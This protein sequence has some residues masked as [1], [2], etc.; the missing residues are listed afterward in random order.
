MKDKPNIVVFMTDQ[1]NAA[2]IGPGGLADTPHV[3]AF[4]ESAVHFPRA[5]C[6]APHCCPSRATLFTGLYPS[7]HGVWNNVEVDNA[8]SRGVYDD[9][10]MFPELLKENGYNTLF[11]G[12]WH[13]SAYEG[14][15]DRGFDRVLREYISNYGRREPR[16]LPSHND[17]EHV[18]NGRTPMDS[19]DTPKEFGRIVREGYPPLFM[20]GAEE[21]PF[22]DGDTA[23]LACEA[24]RDYDSD[25][26]FFLYVGTTGPHDPYTP[27]Q[28]FL[29][30]YRNRDIRLPENFRD[31]M[32]DKPG[33]YRR[34]RDMFALS[35]DEHREMI[36]RYLAFCSYE[37]H[38]FGQLVDAL[39]AKGIYDDTLIV[40]LSD[41]GEYMGAHGLWTKGLP[42]F[43]EAYRICAVVGG[44]G[45][46]GGRTCDKLI[47][48]AD[49]APTFLDAAGVRQRG[50]LG[51]SL[52]PL[53]KSG[54]PT[55]WRSEMY[56]QTNGNE[57]YGIQRAVWN[58]R[59][60]YVLNMFDY[61]E[62]YDLRNDPL[63]MTNL[64]DREEYKDVVRDLC[65]KIWQFARLTGDTCTCPYVTTALAPYGPGIVYAPE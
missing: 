14:P 36:R 55:A 46:E 10:R 12:K 5:Y 28:E 58:D 13:V 26:P 52:L 22:G 20:F 25:S 11:A 17:W 44:G 63:E 60:K 41:H 3:D 23:A 49:F 38:L 8:L 51:C 39:K 42:C 47:S 57:A 35:E 34:T 40:Y 59:W 18:F 61:D 16:N 48:L 54:E 19:A 31:A 9:V 37:D 2:T 27:P 56:T 43:D 6:P 45:I 65:R 21:N 32:A 15:L 4:M 50:M 62:L 30:L 1:Q 7:Q 64:I 24:I 33:L 29:D 53:L